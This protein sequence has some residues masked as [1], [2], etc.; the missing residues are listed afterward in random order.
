MGLSAAVPTGWDPVKTY[1]AITLILALTSWPRLARVV[2]SKLLEVRGEDFVTAA[3]LAGLRD[4]AIILRH[5]LPASLSYLIVHMTL[6]IPDMILA[7]TALSFLGL[8]QIG[9]ASCRERV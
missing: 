3:R 5:M 1:F 2:R 6:A 9:R 7:E 8:G 4:R